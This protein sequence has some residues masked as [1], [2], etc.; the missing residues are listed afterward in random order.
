[1]NVTNELLLQVLKMTTRI[2]GSPRIKISLNLRKSPTR[3]TSRSLAL[4][5][6]NRNKMNRSKRLPKFS[7]NHQRPPRFF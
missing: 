5:K 2:L 6:F 7:D 4:K 3:S 1:M